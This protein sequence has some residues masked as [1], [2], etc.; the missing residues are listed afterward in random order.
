MRRQLAVCALIALALG[1]GRAQPP[2]ALIIRGGQVYDGVALEP[3]RLD[4]AITGDRIV[5]MGD[6]PRTRAAHELDA[7][8][9]LVAPGF[10][11]VQS[12]SGVSLLAGGPSPH[13][14]DGITS[15]VLGDRD[16]PAFWTAQSADHA[17][18]QQLNLSLNWSDMDGY[19][20]RLASRGVAVNV[21]TLFPLPPADDPSAAVELA[22][23]AGALGVSLRVPAPAPSSAN[24]LRTL[25]LVVHAHEGVLAVHLPPDPRE[26]LLA[27][28]DVLATAAATGVSVLIFQPPS[29]DTAVLSEVVSRLVAARTRG[30]RVHTTFTPG[31]GTPSA[32]S[33]YWLRDSGASV[34]SAD[35]ARSR[36][37]AD[38]STAFAHVFARYVLEERLLTPGQAIQRMTSTAAGALGLDG[39][40]LLRVGSYADVVIFDPARPSSSWMRHVIV[41]GVRVVEAS[42]L[43]GARPGQALVGRGREF[44]APR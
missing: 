31:D 25:A 16:S 38:A 39:R 34:G 27:L 23:R 24:A 2:P 3:Q 26:M 36:V 33:A 35:E 13:V 6:L 40:G 9:L 44:S 18:M 20:G 41:N 30:L 22:M 28:D 5:A 11:D 10:I 29:D 1:C 42:R 43:T 21:G 15:V 14:L 19:F 32:A 7:T 17:A 12:R 4:V 8:G 37:Q